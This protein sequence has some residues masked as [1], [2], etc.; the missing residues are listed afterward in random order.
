MW[1]LKPIQIDDRS[2][3][4]DFVRKNGLATLISNGNEYP[5]ATHVPI[6]W[7][8]SDTNKQVLRGHLSKA[9]TQ[10]EDFLIHP[11]VLVIFQSPVQHYISSS[12]YGHPNAPTWNYMSVHITGEVKIIEGDLLWSSVSR[13]TDKYEKMVQNPISLNT[14]PTSVQKQMQGVVGFEIKIDN[15]QASFKMSQNR[16]DEDYQSIIK[17][18]YKLGTTFSCLMADALKL[19][20]P[21][22]F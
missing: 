11:K 14:L 10:W 2:I 22:L 16:S 3:I 18:L 19:N 13:L 6:E 17:E 5:E 12:W 7:E 8:T 4:E 21:S 1:I 20:R 9:N 15:I